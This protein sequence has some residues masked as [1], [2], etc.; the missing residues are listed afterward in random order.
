MS[1]M[2]RRPIEEVM[3]E[4]LES[5]LAGE[6]L[7]SVLPRY[8]E[9]AAELGPLLTTARAMRQSPQP[10]LPASSLAAIL[11]R[12]QEQTSPRRN[13]IAPVVPPILTENTTEEHIAHTGAENLLRTRQ[14][15]APPAK[16]ISLAGRIASWLRV[17]GPLASVPGAMALALVVLLGL[18]VV[19]RSIEQE[20]VNVLPVPTI[21]SQFT[22]D[23]NIDRMANDMWVV[24][25]STIYLDSSTQIVGSPAIG[26]AAHVEGDI[27]TGNRQLARLI[28]VTGTVPATMAP[29]ATAVTEASPTFRPTLPAI[30]GQPTIPSSE[31][32]PPA[33][34]AVS[35]PTAAPV[36][37]P[38]TRI[39]AAP[40]AAPTRPLPPTVV[41][42]LP[43]AIATTARATDTPTPTSRPPLP[44][45]TSIPTPEITATS[46]PGAVTPTPRST[47]TPVVVPTPEPTHTTAPRPTVPPTL[48]PTTPPEPEDTETPLPL[49]T[50]TTQPTIPP[51]PTQ[52]TQPQETETEEPTQVPHPTGTAIP[53]QTI[54]P[55]PTQTTQPQETHTQE[56]GETRTAQPTET[57]SHHGERTHT[58]E[59]THN[60]NQP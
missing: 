51:L 57:E 60:A 40:T 32:Q 28:K 54:P 39:N 18:F 58:P 9:Y 15:A 23:G 24:G 17:P 19:L 53:T 11:A 30:I 55:L 50:P 3:D 34:A 20:P 43:P 12:A 52:T 42:A 7:E 56:P 36:N 4:A 13:G 27:T 44:T 16:K 22:L 35:L 38:T 14:S 59:P 49:N 48:E 21:S 29:Q 5:L 33:T 37:T 31:T 41:P 26:S 1:A 25:G 6:S 10:Q 46:T 45:N 8:P 47:D 2:G